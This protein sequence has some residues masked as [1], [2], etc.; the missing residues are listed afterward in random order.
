METRAK[1]S[2]AD[3]SAERRLS[4]A[5]RILIAVLSLL[6]ACAAWLPCL[7]Y[8]FMPDLSSYRSDSGIAP[9]TKMIAQ[10]HIRLWT[11]PSLRAAEIAKMRRHN[12]EWDFMGRTFLVL[13]L[14]N[15]AYREPGGKREYLSIIDAIIEETLKLE[16]DNGLYF[17]LMPYAKNAPFIQ[18]PARSL[19][20]D[21]E[22]AMMI[23]A[24]QLVSEKAGYAQAL[25]ARIDI[26]VKRMDEAPLHVCES[27]P[28]ECWMFCNAAALA[29]VR[30]SDALD[31]RSH[32]DFINR[33]LKKIRETLVHRE[34]GMLISSF[35]YRGREF[36]GPEGSSIWTVSHFLKLADPDFAAD[37]YRRARNELAAG[38][39]GFGYAREWPASRKG[40]M[41]IDSGPVVP[42]LGISAGSTGQALLAAASFGDREYLA[43]LLATLELGGFPVER[44]G[45]I[46]Y[47]ASNQVGDAVLLYALV[48][49]PLWEDVQA[50]RGK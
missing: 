26:I 9:R 28:D 17:F 33:C 3:S 25:A 8:F 50:R 41:D 21:G 47:A 30:M 37:Q 29:A 23:A 12:A 1:D 2:S 32:D 27:Y 18:Q 48:C 34:T 22:I 7:R 43:E 39:L 31:G 20:V 13:S 16:K 36:D 24:R 5:G 4:P 6:V 46:K 45:C 49:G 42:V 15:M 35:S 14:A 40:R 38:V 19:F 44:D 11:E 10:R